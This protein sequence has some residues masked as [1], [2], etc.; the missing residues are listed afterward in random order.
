MR[1][2]NYVS[3]CHRSS[4]CIH[5]K[6]PNFLMWIIE[7]I[8]RLS[9]TILRDILKFFCSSVTIILA[10]QRFLEKTKIFYPAQTSPLTSLHGWRRNISTLIRDDFYDDNYAR[11]DRFWLLL[12]SS[13]KTCCYCCLEKKSQQWDEESRQPTYTNG[14]NE[15]WNERSFKYCTQ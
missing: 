10:S 1:R 7:N 8:V 4:V 2:W 15:W 3:T 6:F 12:Q 9:T 11:N 5:K 14:Y 13:W